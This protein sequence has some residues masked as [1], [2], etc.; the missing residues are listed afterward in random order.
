[1][2]E[3]T[4]RG[5]RKWLEDAGSGLMTCCSARR[6][7]GVPSGGHFTFTLHFTSVTGKHSFLLLTLYP[8]C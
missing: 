8:F 5:C 3:S 6:H 2:Y 4:L 7:Y 1:M